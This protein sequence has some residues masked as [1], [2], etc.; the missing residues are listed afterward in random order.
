[1]SSKSTVYG[2]LAALGLWAV[3]SA[4][5]KKQV[6]ATAK[7]I[8]KAAR[9]S[10]TNVIVKLGVLNPVSQAITL[11]SLVAD[12]KSGAS[13]IAVV[14]MFSPVRVAANSETDIELTFV[15]S[16]LGLLSMV[17]AFVA[18]PLG[19]MGFGL[20]GT[21]NVDGLALPIETKF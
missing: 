18:N 6:G 20:S 4:G 7:F 9:I 14:K 15:P 3:I 17:R 16:G 10:G 2:V 1:M 5:K 8:V 21:A 12:L 11:N 19:A 13:T